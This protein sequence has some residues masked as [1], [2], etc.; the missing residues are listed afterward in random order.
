MIS[1]GGGKTAHQNGRGTEGLISAYG[2]PMTLILSKRSPLEHRHD[3]KSD[4]QKKPSRYRPPVSSIF[5]GTAPKRKGTKQDASK[6][7]STCSSVLKCVATSPKKKG[8]FQVTLVSKI[9]S[10]PLSVAK[11]SGYF[12]LLMSIAFFTHSSIIQGFFRAAGHASSTMNV[13]SSFALAF[14]ANVA[15]TNAPP[16]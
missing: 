9:R 13:A 14:D 6:V 8:G 5:R 11:P 4:G 16:L 10:R 12:F 2:A 7:C 3:T 15:A 1:L